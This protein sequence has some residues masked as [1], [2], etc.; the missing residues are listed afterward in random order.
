[1][2]YDIIASDLDGTLLM[3][4]TDVSDENYRA[5]AEY[6]KMGGHVVP[7]SGRCFYEMPKALRECEDIRYYISSNGAVITDTE[8]GARNEVLISDGKFKEVKALLDSYDTYLN[9]HVGGYGFI[10]EDTD[11]WE[12][13]KTYNLNTYYYQHYHDNSKK[14]ASWDEALTYGNGVEM[15]AVFFKSQEA[16]D[17]CVSRLNALGGVIATS[18]TD[19]NVEIIAEGASKGDGVRRL[20]GMLGISTDKI[21]GV[22]DSP[23]DIALLEGVGLPLAV[24]NAD[25]V[26][27]E[28]AKMV[29]CHH[30]EH[31][32]RY[33]LHEIEF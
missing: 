28:K 16:L 23:N 8:T 26:L 27:K 3:N 10:L 22:G 19:F 25:E 5:I 2:N 17:E 11:S 4:V 31:I 32:I 30:T 20:A 15:I 18:S 6:K 24:S 9:L 33:I 14:V 1:M 29:I 12:L 7:A 21:I 13:A